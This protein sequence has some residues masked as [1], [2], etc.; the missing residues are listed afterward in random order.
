MKQGVRL[1]IGDGKTTNTWLYPW[2][3]THPLRPPRKKE[4]VET[5]VSYVKYLIDDKTK[6]WNMEN[7]RDVVDETDVMYIQ[8]ILLSSLLNRDLLG[9]HY[10]DSG[11]YTV[12]SGYWLATPFLSIP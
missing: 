10:T 12:K 7:V 8:N 6:Q 5:F 4:R 1:L 11:L 9:W 3:L 2:L